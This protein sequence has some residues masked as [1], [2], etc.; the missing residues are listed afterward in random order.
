MKI[1]Q[2][3]KRAKMQEQILMQT[4]Q[5]K[6]SYEK[7][8]ESALADEAL[9]DKFL[10]LIQKGKHEEEAAKKLQKAISPVK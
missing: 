9:K 1:N 4:M 2:G 7:L 5:V 10:D 8:I 6:L 3:K